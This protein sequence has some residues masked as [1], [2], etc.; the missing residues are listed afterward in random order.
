M[1]CNQCQRLEPAIHEENNHRC[2]TRHHACFD[3]LIESANRGC[4]LCQLFRPRVEHQKDHRVPEEDPKGW[5]GWIGTDPWETP[6][7]YRSRQKY[8]INGN[9]YYVDFGSH[10][11]LDSENARPA[12]VQRKEEDIEENCPTKG[13]RLGQGREWRQ[14][15]RFDDHEIFQWLFKHGQISSGPEQIWIERKYRESSGSHDKGQR[16]PISSFKLSA[17][18]LALREHASYCLEGRKFGSLQEL[19]LLFPGLWKWRCVSFGQFEFYVSQDQPLSGPWQSITAK[20]I[21]AHAELPDTFAVLNK[22]LLNCISNHPRCRKTEPA[23]LP[24]RLIDVGPPDG[25]KSPRLY[26]REQWFLTENSHYA[27]LSHCWGTAHP[28][29]SQFFRL[30]LQNVKSMQYNIDFGR[31]P[32]NFQDAILITRALNLRYLWIDALCILQDCPEDWASEASKMAQYYS[33]SEI[34]IAATAAP[35]AQYGILRSRIIGSTSARLSGE[36]EDLSVRSLADDVLSLITYDEVLAKRQP[37]SCQPLNSRSWAF[38]EKLLSRRIV[39]Y[40]KQQMIWQCQTCLVGEDGQVGEDL[41]RTP[42]PRQVPLELT[43][44]PPLREITAANENEHN[45]NPDL[46]LMAPVKG[47]TGVLYSL[48]E[49]LDDIGWYR[50]VDEY[51]KRSLT[52]S[53]DLLPALSALASEV[54]KLT[55][56]TYLAGLWALDNKIPFKSLLW[57]SAKKNARANNGSPSWAW[58]SVLGPVIHPASDMIRFDHP[59]ARID[60]VPSLPTQAPPTGQSRSLFRKHEGKKK[61]TLVGTR[62]REIIYNHTDSQIEFLSIKMSLATS[63]IFGEVRD[64]ELRITGLVHSYTGAEEYDFAA[65]RGDEDGNFALTEFPDT[66]E[67][68][69]S[70]WK[71]KKHVLLCV[72]EFRDN[73]MSSVS[74]GMTAGDQIQF[75]ILRHLG[76]KGPPYYVRVG[77]A[78]LVNKEQSGF[79]RTNSA[80]T[81]ANGW[82]R[83]TLVLV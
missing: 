76:Q 32:K 64:A 28:E 67:I 44:L 54:K 27:I 33:G 38:Q 70:E 15:H 41:D 74:P 58:S 20:P 3:D 60:W 4:K 9:M 52:Y 24:R 83:E 39:H 25:T 10:Y 47:H 42:S 48:D 49:A 26:L 81:K 79:A 13:F 21:Q 19:A 75:M 57:F 14:N 59:G 80:Y 40:T 61:L 17:G 55:K 35:H 51:T 72:A 29:S 73:A 82:V 46:K 1:L 7:S 16:E 66:D 50:L 45:K 2:L 18:S 62:T 12:D 63:N 30:S 53:S 5:Y 36:A 31:L 68:T 71:T 22:W 69:L 23:D 77:T 6:Y 37:I 43:I 8:H 34:C 56:A 65:E 78:K 11:T